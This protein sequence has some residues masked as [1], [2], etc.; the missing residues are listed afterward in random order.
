MNLITIIIVLIIRARVNNLFVKKR[1]L[2]YHFTRL[3]NPK[4]VITIGD[5]KMVN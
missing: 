5:L 3:P 2:A 4:M 1:S